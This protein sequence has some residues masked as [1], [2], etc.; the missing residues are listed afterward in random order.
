M[1][2]SFSSMQCSAVQCVSVY[3]YMCWIVYTTIN[4]KT[5]IYLDLEHRT[6]YWIEYVTHLECASVRFESKTRF[7]VNVENF[8]EMFW[9]Q[10]FR[11]HCV[12]VLSI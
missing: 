3:D 7:V 4:R 11:I 5:K 6:I 9:L 8:I 1:S 12:W 2:N 10:K